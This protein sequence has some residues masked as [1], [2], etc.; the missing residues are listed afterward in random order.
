MKVVGVIPARM[1]SSRF[2]G[3][4]LALIRG[5]TMIEH[6]YKRSA[7]SKALDTLVVAT[8]DREIAEAVQ[9]FGGEFVMTSPDHQRATDRVAEAAQTVGGDIVIVIQGDEPLV[10]PDMIEAA[11][12]PVAEDGDIFCSNLVERIRTRQEF[13]NPNTIKVTM[14]HQG[15]AL[16]FSREP[17][18]NQT[19]LG[20]DKI[21]A[22]RQVCIIPFRIANLFKFLEL[23][24]T[25]L[26]ETES[27]DMLRI[28][29]H[30]YKVRLVETEYR[31]LSVDMAE[32]IVPVEQA[33][34]RDPLCSLY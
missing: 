6:V 5:K 8:P 1:G 20:F 18:P 2:P 32:E 33:M 3:K 7:L 28:L 34:E 4:P 24:P 12:K 13:E 22:Y 11:V 9:S 10:H 16:Y 25:P 15:N 30:G 21:Q 14:D 29:Q 27:I 17:I 19:I 23:E 31:T 26:E